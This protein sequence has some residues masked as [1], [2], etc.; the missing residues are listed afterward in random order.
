[1]AGPPWRIKWGLEVLRSVSKPGAEGGRRARKEEPAEGRTFRNFVPSG[2]DPESGYAPPEWQSY[3]G[4]VLVARKDKKPLLPQHLEGMWM[5]CYYILDLFGEGKAPRS[6]YRLHCLSHLKL[7]ESL[8]LYTCPQEGYFLVSEFLPTSIQH[9]CQ[10]PH[11]P[12]VPQ[13]SSILYQVHGPSPPIIGALSDVSSGSDRVRC[14]IPPEQGHAKVLVVTTQG[15]LHISLQSLSVYSLVGIL[16]SSQAGRVPVQRSEAVDELLIL[17]THLTHKRAV[18]PLSIAL[19][20]VT[21]LKEYVEQRVLR[22]AAKFFLNDILQGAM[23]FVAVGLIDGTD[24][25]LVRIDKDLGNGHST[26]TNNAL[27]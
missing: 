27:G 9:L 7:V 21:G 22:V 25:G 3:L 16:S 1:M 17:D 10:A 15:L 5:F 8:K 20:V 4:T 11:Y 6:R 26:G 2:I 23:I 19:G 24:L 18:E 12:T 13:L 14:S